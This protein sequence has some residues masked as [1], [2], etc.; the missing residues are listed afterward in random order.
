MVT[1]MQANVFNAFTVVARWMGTGCS[2]HRA[3][4]SQLPNSTL[5]VCIQWWTDH[6]TAPWVQVRLH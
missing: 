1:N 3:A 6:L 4:Q 2:E 5:H